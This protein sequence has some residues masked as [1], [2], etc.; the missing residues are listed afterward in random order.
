MSEFLEFG[1]WDGCGCIL[2]LTL[3]SET[4]YVAFY[5]QL[6]RHPN[7][8]FKHYNMFQETESL[9]LSGWFKTEITKPLKF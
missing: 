3:V 8:T 6:Q 1:G 7:L 2:S 5:F 4:F 9:S